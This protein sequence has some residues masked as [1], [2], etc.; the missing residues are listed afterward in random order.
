[1]KR[2]WLY[3]SGWSLIFGPLGWAGCGMTPYHGV[4]TRCVRFF[5]H[6]LGL[7]KA[8]MYIHVHMK[9]AFVPSRSAFLPRSRVFSRALGCGARRG[10]ACTPGASL[11]PGRAP[12]RVVPGRSKSCELASN[13]G[14]V[15]HRSRADKAHGNTQNAIY[16]A[17]RDGP[18]W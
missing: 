1:M 4:Y 8:I 7:L 17:L 16:Q 2:R 18:A 13:H 12:W 15:F 3:A 5:L 10:A 9:R 6:S 11:G 14:I